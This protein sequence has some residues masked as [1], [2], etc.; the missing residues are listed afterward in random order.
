MGASVGV[1]THIWVHRYACVFKCVC[2]R[3]RAQRYGWVRVPRCTRLYVCRYVWSS[4]CA[5]MRACVWVCLG[6]R[7][8]ACMCIRAGLRTS[9]P[10]GGWLSACVHVYMSLCV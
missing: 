9:V 1:C 10:V 8:H 3:V 6:V 7:G 4:V 2:V 5:G